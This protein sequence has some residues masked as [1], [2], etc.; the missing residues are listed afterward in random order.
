MA[1][2][3]ALACCGASGCG[4]GGAGSHGHGSS[5]NAHSGPAGASAPAGGG[6]SPASR[7]ASGLPS[8]GAQ[9]AE[10]H[11]LTALGLPVY[12][13]GHQGHL[14]GLTFDDGPGPYTALALRKLRKH[15]VRATFFVVGKELVNGPTRPRAERAIGAVGDH[16]WTHPFLP[17][18]SA[19]QV[20]D[21]LAR[22]QMAVSRAS[23][24]PVTLFRPPY[25][26]RSAAIDRQS[27]ALGMVEILWNVDSRDSE[28]AD[29]AGIAG[30]VEQGL[31]PGSIILMHENR[32][33]TI[34]ALLTILP[35][36]ARHHVRAVSIPELLAADPPS[37]SQLR[38][39][40]QGCPLVG[41]SASGG[42]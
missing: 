17:G 32:G 8:A 10:L 13:A 28:G 37:E 35:A 15:H 38:A 20:H 36:L 25:G 4:D 33:Q 1:L 31:A 23:G 29:Y 40:P 27:Q 11:R 30:N 14:V 18:L 16:T 19:G 5:A 26:A 9:A 42:G 7:A 34:R 12:C 2:V 21:E 39:G 6:S 24:A 22:T 3:G 41:A